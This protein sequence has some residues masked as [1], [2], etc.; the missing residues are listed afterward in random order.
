MQ[1]KAA[2][3]GLDLYVVKHTQSGSQIIQLLS[4]KVSFKSFQFRDRNVGNSN[5]ITVQ[6]QDIANR[7]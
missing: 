7:L 1:H 3:N 2:S 6:N 5:L 4:F